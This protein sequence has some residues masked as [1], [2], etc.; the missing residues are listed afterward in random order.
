M[1]FQLSKRQLN[2]KRIFIMILASQQHWLFHLYQRAGFGAF[3]G[4]LRKVAGKSK[5]QAVAQLLDHAAT[6]RP[7]RV[8]EASELTLSKVAQMSKEERKELKQ[9]SRQ[10]IKDLNIQWLARMASGEGALRV[11]MTL[12][13]VG[14][15]ACGSLFCEGHYSCRSRNAFFMQQ[16]YNVLHQHA[17]GK[18]GDLLLEV[19]K[20]PAML[21]F[22]NNQQNRKDAPNENFARE[23]MELFTLGRGHYSEG[24][25]KNAARAFTGWGFTPDGEY[26]FR[27]YGHDFG[28]KTFMGKKGT[29]SGEEVLQLILENPQTARFITQKVFQFFVNPTPDPEIIERLSKQFYQSGYDIANLMETILTADWFYDSKNAGVR[30]KSP[31]ELLAGLQGTFGVRF[32]Q[33]QSLLFI[34]KALGQVLFYPPNVAGWP[35]GQNWIDSSSLLF[36]MQLPE[37][38][39]K[40][41]QVTINAKDEGDVNT[42][43]L[44][45][46]SGRVLQ[47]TADW[48]PLLRHF[49]AVPDRQLL[50]ELAAYLLPIPL[51]ET[52]K[53][54]V[55]SRADKTNRESLLK[56]LSLALISLP[57]YQLG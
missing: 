1:F 17:L 24:D 47:A 42:E 36:R 7:L 21:Q 44:S 26:Q 32:E 56:S 10:S 2:G 12:F 43:F 4:Q 30:I 5:K 33:E 29:F 57:E 52:Q 40:S 51:S 49:S 53:A 38:I 41:A 18:F 39:F 45:R 46:R 23:V 28:E 3:P 14:H 11:M 8:V 19:S 13:W 54:L 50:P 16:Y 35:G 34:Q 20:T 31:V 22:L 48:P 37:V 6:V 27:R 9:D 55:Q 25:I 15:F